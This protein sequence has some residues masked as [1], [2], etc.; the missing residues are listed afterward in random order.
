MEIPKSSMASTQVADHP[1]N[2]PWNTLKKQGL[3]KIPSHGPLPVSVPGAVDGW[4]ELHQKFGSKPMNEI[5]APAI[6][7]AEKGFPLTELI[8]WYMQ[9]TIPFFESR[10]FPNIGDTYKSQNGGKLPNEGEI[11]KNP[12]LANTYRKIAE[13]GRDAF[14]KGEIAKTIGKFIKEQGGFLSAK[15]F[16][17]PQVGMGRAGFY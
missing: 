10:G 1:K 4:F 8:A 3:K 17:N 6:D 14:Y 11:Y 13:G 2:S 5:L 16:S 7:Y 12:Y 9:R 15:D